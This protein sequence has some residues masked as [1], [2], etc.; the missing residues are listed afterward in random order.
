MQKLQ[1]ALKEKPEDGG[2]WTRPK[3]ARWIEKEAGREK[4]ALPTLVCREMLVA[5]I[6]KGIS[7]FER[8]FYTV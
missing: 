1:E 4:V 2:Q 8:T 5:Y 3:V 7:R 6:W